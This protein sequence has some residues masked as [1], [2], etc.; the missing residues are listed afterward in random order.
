MA[1]KLLLATNNAGKVREYRRLLAVP[2]IEL[3]TPAELGIRTAVEET[4]DTLE[5]NARLKAAP[6][7]VQ[8]G[9]IALAD[10]SGL[11]VDALGGEPGVHS[12]RYAGEHATDRDRVAYLL[13]KLTGVPMEK[14]TAH[15]RC[16]IALATP[17]GEVAYARGECHGL[18]ALEPTGENGFGYDPLFYL[19]ELG[20]T[21]AELPSEMKDRVSHRG[22]A[23]RQVPDLL[24]RAP[25]AC[26]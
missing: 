7:A 16:V 19:P 24:R 26:L 8:S 6:L 15:F 23:A 14:R 17:A 18:I 21:M 10:D 20:K 2:G 5:E 25:F 3:L 13:R 11:Y 22:K 9:L 12:A 4:G 1:C